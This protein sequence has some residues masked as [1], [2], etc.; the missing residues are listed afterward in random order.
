MTVLRTATTF[1]SPWSTNKAK[2]KKA[3]NIHAF[4]MLIGWKKYY[5]LK[6]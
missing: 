5:D 1:H 6:M 3:F 2:K 4:S